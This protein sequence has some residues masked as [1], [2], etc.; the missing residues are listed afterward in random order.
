MQWEKDSPLNKVCQ[1]NWISTCKSMKQDLYLM[2]VIKTNS[3]QLKMDYTLKCK[4]W[5]HKTPTWKQRGK[6]SFDIGL[7]NDFLDITPK[8]EA[9]EGKIN[10]WIYIKLK[11][12]CTT[13]EIISKIKRQL[14]E[15]EKICANHIP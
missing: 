3:K 5:S 14:T 7:G 13:K 11:I 10:R 15:W 6:K 12:F 1:W 2:P 4:T 8:A 9:T